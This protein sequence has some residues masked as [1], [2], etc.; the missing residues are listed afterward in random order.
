MGARKDLAKSFSRLTQEEVELFCTGGGGGVGMKFK[1]MAPACDVSIDKCPA[2]SI[3]LYY[4]H[5]EFSNLRHPF[6]LFVLNVVEYYHVSFGQIHPQ[7]L[8]RVLHFE[9][10]CRACGYDPSLLFFRPFFR[11]EKSGDWFTFETSK[12]DVCLVSSMVTTLGSWKDQFFW[13]SNVIVP[14]KMVWWQP[15][16]ILCEPEPSESELNEVF[17]EALRESPSRVN[18]DPV[19]MRNGTVMSALDFIKSDD[20]SDVE[21][22]DALAIPCENV[23]V[24]SSEQRFEGLG[25][26]GVSNVKGFTKPSV[27]KASNRRS[28]RRLRG[29]TQPTSSD[30]VELSDDIEVSEGQGVDVEKEKKL[31]VHDKKK[32]SSKKVVTTPVQGSSSRDVQGLNE[33]EVYV[34][35][36]SVK[37]GDSFKDPNVCADVLTHFAP[38]GVRSA[39]FEMENDQFISRL[40]LSSCNLSALVA[41]GVTRFQKGMQEYKEFSKK[42]EKMKSSMATMK[43]EIDGFP[44]KEEVWAKKVGESTRRHGIEMN[45]LKKS[46]DQLKLKAD[47]EALTVRQKAFE[48]EKEGLKALV[49]QSTG[50]NHWLIEQGFHQVTK[51]LNL[52]KYQ[53]LIAGYKLHES[54]QPL[55]KSPLYRPEASEVSKCSV[56]QMERLTYPYVSQVAACFGKPLFVLQEL[57]PD[58][59]NEK[60]CAE[61]LDSLSRNRSHSGDSEE[62]F[63]GELDA[64]KY[65]SLEGSEVGSDGGSKAKKSKKVK[66]DGSRASKP[67]FDI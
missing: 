10:L 54:G 51:L 45:D 14:F 35:E 21:F 43:K 9:V 25:Y 27:P 13:V 58:G 37:V 31:V 55:E 33:N 28:A 6:S 64:S 1:P 57:K 49:A 26:V 62:T 15:D 52:G 61:V 12:V 38:P 53:G 11:L 66:G 17:L 34:P 41:E 44:K 46:F 50:D 3:A 18:R 20:T 5:F 59:L 67:P 7:G 22:E 65:A 2:G 56:Q 48:E 40:M 16:A 42:K 63:S 19:L 47:G 60:V 30:T 29:A 4:H 8:A 23:V 24:R 39:I 36:W 32:T